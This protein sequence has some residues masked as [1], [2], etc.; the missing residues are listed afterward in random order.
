MSNSSSCIL[1]IDN[2][3]RIEIILVLSFNRILLSINTIINDYNIN[4]ILQQ[5]T[6]QS[7]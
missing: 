1:L 6:D 4:I 7:D 5:Q 2:N 3:F